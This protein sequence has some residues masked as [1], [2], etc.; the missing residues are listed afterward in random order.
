MRSVSCS[1][2]GSTV[3]W[4]VLT[5]TVVTRASSSSKRSSNN[6]ARR[7]FSMTEMRSPTSLISESSSEFLALRS[8]N[9][10][11]SDNSFS[12]E[13]GASSC[14]VSSN[15]SSLATTL[16]TRASW[17]TLEDAPSNSETREMTS[18]T[19][20]S[21]ADSDGFSSKAASREST[22]SPVPEGASAA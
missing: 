19:R 22:S 18:S 12:F 6:W 1:T 2:R 5:S 7:S 20:G 3:D 9:A 14:V 13:M 17:S 8:I 4:A 11:R 16:S 10:K 21:E 15:A